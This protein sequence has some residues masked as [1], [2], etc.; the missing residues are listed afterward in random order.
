MSRPR[1]RRLPPEQQDSLLDA[2]LKEFATHGFAAASLNRI[3]EVTG[4]SKGAM[5]YYFDGKDDLYAEVIRRQVER[6][7][8]H[9]GQLRV[10][11]TAGA[12]AFWDAIEE[13]YLRLMRLLAETPQTGTLLRDWL[14]GAASPAL[15]DAESR[16]EQ[17]MMPWLMQTVSTGQRVGAVRADLPADLLIAVAFGMGQAMDAWLIVQQPEHSDLVDSVHSLIDMMRRALGVT[18]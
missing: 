12:D 1:F 13:Y 3:I 5:Y 11:D 7:L 15:R 10:Q 16:A 2:A 14:S 17:D 18:G 6:M 9:G 4:T 8:E